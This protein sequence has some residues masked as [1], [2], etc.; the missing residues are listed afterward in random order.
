MRLAAAFRIKVKKRWPNEP[1][2]KN[3]CYSEFLEVDWKSL[4]KGEKDAEIEAEL[5]RILE[6]PA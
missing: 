4:L 6:M 2:K 3:I 5:D 1:E